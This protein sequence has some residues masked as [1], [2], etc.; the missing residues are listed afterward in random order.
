M[1]KLKTGSKKMQNKKG[2][3][4]IFIILAIIIVSAILV[5]LLYVKPKYFP[6]EGGRLDFENCVE[7][8][9]NEEID[10]LGRQAGFM[11]PDFYY[12]F[13]D[14]RIGYL[15]YTNL[16]YKPCTVQKPFLK[17]HFEEELK[18]ATREEIGSCYKNSIS[19]LK[20]KGYDV[21]SGEI[22]FNILLNPGQIIVNIDAPTS[23]TRGSEMGSS[24]KSFR[25]V[26]NSQLYD[27][28]M[29]SSSLLQYEARYGDSDTTSL[30]IF[31]PNLI[32]D[33]LK[34]SDGTTIYIV[35]DKNSKTKF[36]FASRSL[37]WP[38]GYSYDAP[39]GFE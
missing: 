34:Q 16:Y 24:Y 10:I 23:V 9:V 36:Q 29:I 14:D 21:V 32:I 28:L 17:Q 12:M 4:T 6:S 3:L 13:K 8:V 11:N 39:E 30:M 1:E 22:D 38:P 33:K 5:Y 20:E 35:Q 27:I 7:S 19:E 31:Y 15:C 2:Q 26:I 25:T 18:K 37:A